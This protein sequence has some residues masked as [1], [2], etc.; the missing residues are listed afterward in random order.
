MTVLL[1]GAAGNIGTTLRD[2]LPALGWDVRCFD[3]EPVP[4]GTTGD[5]GSADDV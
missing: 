2:S 1:T 3:R 4:G 5:L